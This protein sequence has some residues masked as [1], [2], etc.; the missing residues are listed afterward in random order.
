MEGREKP[1]TDICREVMMTVEYF[2]C[3]WFWTLEFGILG[4]GLMLC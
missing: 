3:L 2:H 4:T 1:Q